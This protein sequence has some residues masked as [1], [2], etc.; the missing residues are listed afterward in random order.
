MQQRCSRF[1]DFDNITTTST[2]RYAHR[3]TKIMCPT[4]SIYSVVA[5]AFLAT[6]CDSTE[7]QETPD[8]SKPIQA[9]SDSIPANINESWVE[10]PGPF[11]ETVINDESGRYV[12]LS[13]WELNASDDDLINLQKVSGIKSLKLFYEEITN[14]GMTHV[15]QL[16]DLEELCLIDTNVDT[17]GLSTLRDLPKLKRLML[18]KL[19][20]TLDVTKPGLSSLEGL[21]S[22]EHLT[23]RITSPTDLSSLGK[24]KALKEL[25]LEYKGATAADLTHL[26]ASS[27]LKHLTLNS[28]SLTAEGMNVLGSMESLEELDLSYC[29]SVKAGFD[30]LGQ[31]NRLKKLTLI[32]TDVADEELQHLIRLPDLQMLNLS[33]THI[34]DAGLKYIGELQH[35]R[36]LNLSE[37]EV[38]DDGL[39][40]LLNLKQLEELKVNSRQITD[41]GVSVI[42]QLNNLRTIQL[43][44]SRLTDS[45]LEK[46]QALEHLE[47]LDLNSPPH[48]TMSAVNQFRT[49]RPEINI[50]YYR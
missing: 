11:Y 38:S 4:W 30:A 43:Y 31:L 25:K 10:V 13:S 40:S 27:S 49:V 32:L 28:G 33:K 17:A 2:Q 6:A 7:V 41:A 20:G 14:A 8:N 39:K 46:L 44:L 23:I 29:Q 35:L 48:V 45:G 12:E 50:I 18:V 47:H 34:T 15:G 19:H 22:L 1:S 36:S 37:T 21:T 24:M 42:C 5:I 3:S 16:K 9:E 26:V